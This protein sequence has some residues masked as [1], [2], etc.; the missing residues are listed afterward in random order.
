MVLWVI[1]LLCNK[2]KFEKTTIVEKFQ[3]CSF[4][5]KKVKFKIYENVKVNLTYIDLLLVRQPWSKLM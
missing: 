2:S 5:K 1:K 4:T 3:Y